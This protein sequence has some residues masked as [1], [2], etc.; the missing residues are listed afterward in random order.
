MRSVPYILKFL[1]SYACACEDGIDQVVKNLAREA[2][3]FMAIPGKSI[4]L[5]YHNPPNE[6]QFGCWDTQHQS[7]LSLLWTLYTGNT[8]LLAAGRAEETAGRAEEVLEEN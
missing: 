7:S 4:N 6:R 2:C 3:K 8:A 5:N 1:G